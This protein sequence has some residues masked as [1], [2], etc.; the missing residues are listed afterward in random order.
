MKRVPASM[1]TREELTS[2]IEG[3]LSANK[4]YFANVTQARAALQ[5]FASSTAAFGVAG[6]RVGR[7]FVIS[8]GAS[9]DSVDS[10]RFRSSR[11]KGDV[12]YAVYNPA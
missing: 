4:R 2:L 6:S 9:A 7:A 12:S 1:R 5:L 11:C 8:I 3:R 10:A